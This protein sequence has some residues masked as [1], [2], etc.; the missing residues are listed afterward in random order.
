MCSWCRPSWR[1]RHWASASGA[2]C[3]LPAGRCPQWLTRCAPPGWKNHAVREH[4]RHGHGGERKRGKRH[5]VALYP[6]KEIF[7]Q[8]GDT[9]SEGGVICTLDSS[10]LE[11][12]LAKRQEALAESRETAQR[13]YDKAVKATTARRR[14]RP[15]RTTPTP[16]R[17]WRWKR[18]ATP[19]I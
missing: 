11:E 7:V 19:N 13:N 10:D 2:S 6:V 18:R 14:S 17:L 5:H 3:A 12:Q 4:H 9:V 15:R 8:V 1:L 16:V